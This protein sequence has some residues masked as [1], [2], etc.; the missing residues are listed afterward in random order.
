MTRRW[1]VM[2]RS[3]WPVF[4]EHPPQC[5]EYLAYRRVRPHR[6]QDGRH[7][8]LVRAVLLLLC[9]LFHIPQTLMDSAVVSFRPQLRQALDLL[10]LGLRV[11]SEHLLRHFFGENIL[12]HADHS[13][14][15]GRYLS[16]VS[17]SGL[18]RL[19]QVEAALDGRHR[20]TH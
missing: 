12:V 5:P 20:S 19:L 1:G 8:V 17:V 18:D 6:F 7:N 3:P 13:P 14:L 15:A 10:S 4:P 9:H 11:H 16:L 2:L